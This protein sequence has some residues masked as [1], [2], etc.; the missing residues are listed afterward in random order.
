MEVMEDTEAMEAMEGMAVTVRNV[1]L[2]G[3]HSQ[4]F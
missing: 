3:T 1:Q 4:S 2:M